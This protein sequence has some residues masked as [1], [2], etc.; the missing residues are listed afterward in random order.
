MEKIYFSISEV[1]TLLDINQS[2]LRFWEKEF[3][4]LKPERKGKITRFYTQKDIETIKKI[5]FL[6]ED[7]KLTLSG[8]QEKL[9]QKMD[10]ISKQQMLS[11]RL[12]NLK[13][14]IQG[15]INQIQ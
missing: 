2:K 8:A 14:E 1:A 12:K 4:Q 9:N 7:Q 6:V 3:K 5:K 13:Q 10:S 11:E 15:I